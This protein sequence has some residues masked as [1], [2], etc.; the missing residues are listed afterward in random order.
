MERL[1]IYCASQKWE[2]GYDQ[3]HAD[4]NLHGEA[5]CYYPCPNP[6]IH[7]HCSTLNCGAGMSEIDDLQP[8]GKPKLQGS[9]ALW[10]NLIIRITISFSQR[11][12]PGSC[13]YSILPR[14]RSW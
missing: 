9:F 4:S 6:L 11:G 10:G 13:F 2:N 7:G 1:K 8:T 3:T 12:E 5:S 14:R